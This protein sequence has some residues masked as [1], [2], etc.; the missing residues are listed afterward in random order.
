MFS[1]A[2]LNGPITVHEAAE[3]LGI[4]PDLIQFAIG[5]CTLECEVTRRGKQ[6]VR[7]QNVI[8]AVLQEH[9]FDLQSNLHEWIDKKEAAGEDV[10]RYKC[11]D[12]CGD[13]G[14]PDALC[15]FHRTGTDLT[16]EV[17]VG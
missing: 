15:P 3:R 2:L 13:E 6:V 4:E 11:H 10:L 5:F 8:E 1:E 7:L 14:G 16:V 9:M 17:W 12:C